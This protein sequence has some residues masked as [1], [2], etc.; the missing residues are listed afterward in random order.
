LL[1]A[2]RPGW[3][4]NNAASVSDFFQM[5][6]ALSDS[7]QNGYSLNVNWTSILLCSET[8]VM[9]IGRVR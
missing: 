5:S 8:E 1:P 9:M 3:S 4:G 7:A 6:N 2:S